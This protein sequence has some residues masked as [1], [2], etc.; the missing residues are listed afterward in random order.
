MLSV[1]ERPRVRFSAVSE[2]QMVYYRRP[3]TPAN[4]TDD[5]WR[6][7]FGWARANRHRLTRREYGDLLLTVSMAIAVSA[8][9]RIAAIRIFLH[10]QLH[11][12]PGLPATLF[13]LGMIA[14]P[15]TLRARL[16]SAVDRVQALARPSARR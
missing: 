14:A 16:V 11:G 2:P 9:A 1:G 13:G 6:R 15:P 4:T 3:A 5:H 7:S 8:G 12:R 10:A